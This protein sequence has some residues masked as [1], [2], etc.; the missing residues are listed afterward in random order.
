MYF[1]SMKKYV[2]TEFIELINDHQPHEL[3]SMMTEDHVLVD[4]Q[5]NKFTGLESATEVWKDYFAVWP[6]YWIDMEEIFAVEEKIYGFGTVSGTYTGHLP[7]KAQHFFKIPLALKAI[8]EG[9]KIKSWQIIAD[10]KKQSE[11]IR[12]N[13]GG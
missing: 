1:N 8:V 3:S 5:G 12:K 9:E 4:A 10:T 2:V 11:I 13:T 6:D 7:G